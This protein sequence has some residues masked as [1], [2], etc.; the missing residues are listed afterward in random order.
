MSLQKKIAL[1]MKRRK[2]RVRSKMTSRGLKLRVSVF[3][4]LNHD[5][6]QIIDDVQQ[7]T[8]LSFSSLSL[9][10]KNGSKRELA[11]QVGVELAK[12][13]INQGI[14]EVFFDRGAFLYHGRVREVAEGLREGGLQF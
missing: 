1:R 10:E 12:K 5:Y 14:K 2:Y 7:K 9:S 8:V 6:V 3:R 11:R 13:A 4:S